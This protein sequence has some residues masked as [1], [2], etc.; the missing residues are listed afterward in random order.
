MWAMLSLGQG[1]LLTLA[2]D[3]VASACT[4]L[5]VV[6]HSQENTIRHGRLRDIHTDNKELI[7]YCGVYESIII[8]GFKL[9]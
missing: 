3:T 4:I 5:Y 7:N 6:M 1:A 9:G 2:V 8:S